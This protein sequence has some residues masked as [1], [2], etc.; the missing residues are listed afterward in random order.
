VP[1]AIAIQDGNYVG[2]TNSERLSPERENIV[3]MLHAFARDF[4]G[5]SYLFWVD[6]APYFE[7]DVLPCF[8]TSPGQSLQV[9]GRQ[10]KASPA[11]SA[12]GFTISP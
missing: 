3:P 9:S 11:P 6:Q 5:V 4:L 7:E 2:E 1:L 10:L 12:S 8:T